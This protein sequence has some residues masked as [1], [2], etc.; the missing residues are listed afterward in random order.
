MT[1][2]P[3]MANFK[4]KVYFS[5][6]RALVIDLL[7]DGNAIAIDHTMPAILRAEAFDREAFEQFWQFVFPLWLVDD[8]YS[9]KTKRG[10]RANPVFVQWSDHI[11]L[12]HFGLVKDG[13]VDE[14][15]LWFILKVIGRYWNYKPKPGL[16]FEAY[17]SKVSDKSVEEL[18]AKL[19]D[20][21]ARVFDLGRLPEM[22][23][24]AHQK[25]MRATNTSRRFRRKN[26]RKKR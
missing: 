2:P 19:A 16:L 11:Q 14:N 6:N 12:V 26:K 22:K 4:P 3:S 25:F 17:K 18:L 5:E 10:T 20:K 23:E 24:E 13:K 9:V 7:G 15:R 1:N 21:E 8:Q